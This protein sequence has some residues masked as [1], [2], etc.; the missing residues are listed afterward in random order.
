MDTLLTWLGGTDARYAVVAGLAGAGVLAA[1]WE[2]RRVPPWGF[3]LAIGIAVLTCRWP[4]AVQNTEL[5]IDDSQAIAGAMR[6]SGHPIAWKYVDLNTVGP[7]HAYVLAVLSW[8]G[9]PINFLMSH[10]LGLVWIWGALSGAYLFLRETC[11]DRVARCGMLPAVAFFA[12]TTFFDFAY[13]SSEHLPLAQIGL[14]SALL[15][16]GAHRGG[17][18]RVF[19]GTLLLGATPWSKLQGVPLALWFC[20]AGLG[21]IVWR[22]WSDRPRLRRLLGAWLAGG[23]TVNLLFGLML[24]IWGLGRQWYHAY[25]Q[26]ALYYSDMG[27][28]SFAG[29]WARAPEFLPGIPEAYPFLLPLGFV[30]MVLTGAA[31]STT[32]RPVP[33]VLFLIG[34]L[35]VAAWTIAAPGRLFYHYL[36]FGVIPL[37][38]LLAGLLEAVRHAKQERRPRWQFPTLLVV[39]LV[40]TLGPQVRARTQRPHPA[41]PFQPG[42]TRLH[43]G[44]TAKALAALAQPGDTM[45]VWGWDPKLYVESGLVQATRDGQTERQISQNPLLSFYRGRYLFDLQ[46][47][48]PRFFVEAVGPGHFLY[49]DRRIGGIEIWPELLEYVETN[50]EFHAEV[51][52]TRIFV[53]R[54]KIDV[55][56]A[57]RGT[58]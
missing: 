57:L 31:L 26:Q 12:L 20:L 36:L 6:L 14:G 17:W 42:I 35:G 53:R 19:L 13:T 50:Y 47:Y 55:A 34:T 24:L 51:E 58:D 46:R 39:F 28:L 4:I 54:P 49:T 33:L 43:Q 48:Q 1:A 41:F 44:E 16:Q 15:W 30:G 11:D 52:H 32:R 27:G 40:V 5:G 18:R 37:T 23:L 10:L 2:T 21:V 25:I 9:F 8:I 22:W 29:F 7:L 3:V 38:M 56:V 45:T